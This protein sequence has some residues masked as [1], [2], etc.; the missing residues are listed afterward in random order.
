MSKNK[1]KNN[2]KDKDGNPIPNDVLATERL[3]NF[4]RENVEAWLRERNEVTLDILETEQHL[5]RL[6]SYGVPDEMIQD[7][8]KKM[9]AAIYARNTYL[10]TNIRR[11]AVLMTRA[12]GFKH[13]SDIV[14][15]NLDM[16]KTVEEKQAKTLATV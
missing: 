7:T 8:R 1:N 15:N 6:K 13:W 10:E 11:V 4:S 16:L 5:A 9:A 3:E 12:Q 14:T 2:R